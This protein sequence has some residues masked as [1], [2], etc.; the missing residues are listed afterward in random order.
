MLCTLDKELTLC[1]KAA[2][3]FAKK[4]LVDAREERDRYPHTPFFLETVE[5][6]LDV[7]LFGTLAPEAL[8]GTGQD[9]RALC[10]ILENLCRADASLGGV[11]FTTTM[12]QE[13]LLA[14][15]MDKVVK[16]SLAGT[17]AAALMGFPSFND[18]AAVPH[19]LEA[20][21]AGRGFRLS[22]DLEYLVLGGVAPRAVVPAVLAGEEGF[23]WYLVDL[24]HAGVQ[25]SAPVASL[26]LHA[27]P[28]VDV[29]MDKVP[30]RP[31][32]APGA[33]AGL[34]SMVAD[35][36][37][38]AA[39]AMSLGVLEGSYEDAVAYAKQR[40]QG[41]R[42]IVGWSELR[43]VLANMAVEAKV[44]EMLVL[45]ACEAMSAREKGW[46][47]AA[48]ACALHVSRA[49][50]RGTT[51]GVQVYGGAGYMK[52]YPQEKRMRDAKQ[53]QTLLGMYH[54][55]VLEYFDRTVRYRR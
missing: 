44:C 38:V 52:D 7:G 26:G 28:A 6:A 19:V 34:F 46:E 43:M 4:E 12:A 3:E 16:E 50:A 9:M 30:A 51:D 49:V 15:G 23:G 1:D 2:R 45:R 10:V 42:K 5:R 47:H 20:K 25:K 40:E 41:G 11:V 36:L 27:C 53:L 39:A 21:K 31:V 22:G 48:R 24:A 13:M 17:A 18:P 54:V 35:R 55:R 37:Q 8:G 33:G 29:R 14:A 32:G